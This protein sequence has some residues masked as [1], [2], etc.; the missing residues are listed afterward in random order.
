[1]T[2]KE[3][4]AK[5]KDL[6]IDPSGLDTNDKLK[7]AIE[8]KEAEIAEKEAQEAAAK[9][10]AE[11]AEAEAAA[12]AAQEAEE[13]AKAEAEAKAKAEAEAEKAEAEAAAKAAQEAEEKAKA[14]AEAKAKAEAEAA[15]KAKEE[16]T[17]KDFWEDP[18][19]VK[20][21]FKE[22][23]PQRLNVDGHSL[24]RE[25]ILNSEEIISELVYGKCPHLTRKQ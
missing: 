15:A 8:A 6:G 22:N 3:L 18:A 13:K 11:K 10:E 5:C 7:A 19:G 9:A 14:E 23:A 21:G 2:K 1:M 4:I 24:T 20:W 12:K 16:E 17:A 25:E